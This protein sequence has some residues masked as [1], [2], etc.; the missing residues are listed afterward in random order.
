MHMFRVACSHIHD[1]NNLDH[2]SSESSSFWKVRLLVSH[3]SES[4][5][6]SRLLTFPGHLSSLL[7]DIW[8]QNWTQ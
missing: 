8:H 7:S 1:F 5:L 6:E 2:V 4:T 3:Y